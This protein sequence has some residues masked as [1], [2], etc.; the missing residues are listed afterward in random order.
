MPEPRAYASHLSTP[1]AAFLISLPRRKQRVVLDLADKLARNP[2]RVS[3]YQLEDGDGR[4]VDNLTLGEFLF[5]YWVDHATREVR[6]A[7]IIK[8]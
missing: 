7:E 5:S 6:I 8:L 3:D 2:F 4:M 1:A